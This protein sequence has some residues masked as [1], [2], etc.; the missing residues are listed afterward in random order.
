MD[1]AKELGSAR[2]DDDREKNQESSVKTREGEEPRLSEVRLRSEEIP[3]RNVYMIGIVRDVTETH[4]FRPTLTYLD[5]LSRKGKRGGGNDSDSDDGPPPDPDDPAPTVTTKKEKKPSG[6]AREVQ[7]SARRA[8]DK[9]GATVG[10]LSAVR[11]EMLHILRV[12]EDEAWE[13]LEF[14]DVSVRIVTLGLSN[15]YFF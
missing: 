3:H 12:E 9:S 1:K 7:V 8:D 14:S 10:G 6:D 13:P 5:A 11:R 2:V 15:T 4:Q